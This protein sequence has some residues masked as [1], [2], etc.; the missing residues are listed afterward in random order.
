MLDQRIL[1]MKDA[2]VQAVQ[3]SVRIKSV[4]DTARENMPFGEGVY[5]A[6]N[7]AMKLS[8]KLGFKAVNMD[9]M[10]GY[11]EYGQGE[12][13]VAV[14]G[15]LDV[16]PEGEGWSYPPYGAEIHDSRIYGRGTL[17]NKGPIIGAL[18]ALKAIKDLKIPLKKRVRIIFGTNEESGSRGV[19]Y[20]VQ[21]EEVPV[22]GFTPDAEYPIIYAEKGIVIVSHE[23]QFKGE[24]G[25]ICLK[26]FKGGVAANVVPAYAKALLGM[27]EECVGEMLECIEKII[28]KNGWNI[29][30]SVKEKSKDIQ[31][32][33]YGISAHGSTPELGKNAIIPL[34]QLLNQLDI[35]KDVKELFSFIEKFIGE[36]T[37][38]ESL[39]IGMEDD[40]SGKFTLNLGTM[41]GND[42]AMEFDVNIRY[43]VTGKYDDF[44]P[45]LQEIMKENHVEI[46]NI[47]HKAPLYIPKEAELIQKLQKVYQ[48]KMNQDP[49]LLAIGGGTYAKS[50]KN[51]VAFGPIFPGEPDVIHQPDEYITIDNLIKNVQIMAAAIYELAR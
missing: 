5:T 14:L 22:L 11:A 41:T 19:E 40:I 2:I 6:L 18:F 24:R 20:Y 8:E 48:E 16:V 4:E 12:E 9:N 17:D 15:H 39:K 27:D 23:K 50:M 45:K 49:E 30:A 21:R 3:E 13:M 28:E 1:E 36:E 33:S 42:G 37:D 25:G 7:H 34:L 46:K 35:K 31:L 47:R 38:G 44:I 32:L 26:S 10:I 51:I 29:E 43:P